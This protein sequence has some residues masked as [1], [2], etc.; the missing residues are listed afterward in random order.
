MN[1]GSSKVVQKAPKQLA[2]TRI[3]TTMT[4][5]RPGM[6]G[7]PASFSR[8]AACRMFHRFGFSPVF[9]VD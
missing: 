9:S 3:R 6:T 4:Q 5:C 7:T 8:L 1:I 2:T